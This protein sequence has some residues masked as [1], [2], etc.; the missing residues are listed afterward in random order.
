MYLEEDY[1]ALLNLKR[2][3]E[4][5]KNEGAGKKKIFYILSENLCCS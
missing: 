4:S 5:A 2:E 1:C 3:M